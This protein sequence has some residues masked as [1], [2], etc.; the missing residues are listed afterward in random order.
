VLI[1]VA[2]RMMEFGENAISPTVLAVTNL[3]WCCTACILSLRF[4]IFVLRCR[5][6]LSVR[7]ICITAHSIDVTQHWLCSGVGKC[8]RGSITGEADR[9]MY[10]VK[11]QRTKTIS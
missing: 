11:N 10:Q 9:N 8:F 2:S 4:N 6:S 3:P 7:L 1:E 5:S